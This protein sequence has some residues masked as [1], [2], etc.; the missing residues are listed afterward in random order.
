MGYHVDT[1][2]MCQMNNFFILG[3]VVFIFVIPLGL[4]FVFVAV[5][6][7]FLYSPCLIF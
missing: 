5:A 2:G 4:V 6:H 3:L 1:S 7:G